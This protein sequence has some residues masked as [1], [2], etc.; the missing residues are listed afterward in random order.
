MAK[1]KKADGASVPLAEP[2]YREIRSVLESAR[3]GAYHA[4]YTAMVRAYWQVGRL[5][6]EYEQG[7]ERRAAYGEALLSD[8]SRRLTSEFGRG[9]DARNLRYMRQF[10]LAFPAFH[11][12]RDEPETSVKRN[13][14]R[15]ESDRTEKRNALR[16]VS[17]ESV[18]HAAKHLPSTTDASASELRPELSWTHYRLLLRVEDAKARQWY[19]REAADQHWS[20]RQLERQISTLY[21]ERLLASRKK[22]PVRKE[23]QEKLAAVT[24][25]HFIRDP[26]VRMF[27]AH[28]RPDADNPTIGLILCSKKNE[29]I[30]RY[31]VLSEGKQLFAAK[32][33]EVLPTEAELKREIERERRLIESHRPEREDS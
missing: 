29:A 7:G 11:V 3:T 8:L 13:A 19:L 1:R 21:Y 22:G 14:P 6:V 23:A 15:S 28:A 12:L 24:P 10:Y 18:E 20:S 26:Y 33:M 4:V 9:F 5:I 16:S 30:V 31:S 17:S 27:D 25:E 32:Y 2:L